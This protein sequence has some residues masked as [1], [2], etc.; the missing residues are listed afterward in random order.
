MLWFHIHT[1][2]IQF[3]HF[4]WF[5]VFLLLYFHCK[6]FLFFL[7]WTICKLVYFTFNFCIL[8]TIDERAVRPSFWVICGFYLC[9]VMFQFVGMFE[10][11]S[12]LLISDYFALLSSPFLLKVNWF[13]LMHRR[14][15]TPIKMGLGCYL[16]INV[17]FKLLVIIYGIFNVL[18]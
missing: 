15:I 8:L 2:H 11:S 17:V 6:I 7:L 5:L 4:Q 10:L 3:H 18:E 1:S 12:I 13:I 16:I 9:C 14:F